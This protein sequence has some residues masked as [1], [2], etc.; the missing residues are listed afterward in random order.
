MHQIVRP[1]APNDFIIDYRRM[2]N[3][4]HLELSC[5]KNFMP[6]NI[7][8]ARNAVGAMPIYQ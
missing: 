5:N 2:N 1:F 6:M 7:V 8:T 3:K 4:N